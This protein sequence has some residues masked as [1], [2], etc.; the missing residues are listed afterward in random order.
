M[1]AK[2]APTAAIK[3]RKQ[4]SQE[5]LAAVE[6]AVKAMV[7]AGIPIESASV[8]RHAGVSRT[9]TYQN[10]T[11]RDLIDAAK[12]RTKAKAA[13]AVEERVT[14]ISDS[15]RERAL[16]AEDRVREQREELK[17]ARG[18]IADLLGQIRD[19]EGV[20][21][22]DERQRLLAENDNL[23]RELEKARRERDLALQQR[24]SARNATDRARHSKVTQ[25]FRDPD[26]PRDMD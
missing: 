18:Q 5:C 21:L 2:S 3:A 6:R 11:A 25:M 9:F 22:H 15:W 4:T 20:W 23:K 19:S 10:E 17:G 16:N 7:K 24:D 26:N 8:A 14:A 13:A 1:T 12:A